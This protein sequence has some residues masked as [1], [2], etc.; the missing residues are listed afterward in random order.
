MLDRRQFLLLSASAAA[1][2]ITGRAHA[3][4]DRIT[5]SAHWSP[6]LGRAVPY[7]TYSATRAGDSAPVLYLLHGHGGGE[8]DWVRAGGA[9][10]TVDEMVEARMLPPLHLI[11]PGVGNS[12]YVDGPAPHGPVAT[13]LLDGLMPGVEQALAPKAAW[14]AVIGLSMGGFGAL[15]LGLQEPEDWRFIG[16]LSPAIFPPGSDFPGFQLQLFSGAFGTPFDR[17]RF[18]AADPFNYVP[19]LARAT[20]QPEL[21]LSC[22]IDD[23]FGLAA[24]TRA[25]GEALA[26]AAVPATVLIKPGRHDW[27]YWRAELPEALAALGSTVS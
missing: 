7:L 12:W 26:D 9:I 19:A 10:E 4:R 1:V 5:A 16:A 21:Y 23:F 27:A 2:A 3:S 25:F 15:H 22:G 17:A 20:A 24:G 6:V 13:T 8:W 18:A 11:L 14:R